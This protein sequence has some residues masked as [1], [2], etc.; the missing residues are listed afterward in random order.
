EQWRALMGGVTTVPEWSYGLWLSRCFYKDE[1]EVRAV[2]ENNRKHNLGA[3]VINLDARAWM[4]AQTRTDFVWDTSRW[5]PYKTFIP[6]LREQGFQVC[7]WENPYVSSATETLYAEGVKNGY[8]AKTAKG[9]VYPYQWVPTGL[10]GFPQPPIA[11]LVDF[12]NA[13]ARTWWKDQH[14]SYL[15]AGVN[16]FKTDFGE[17]IPHDAVFS[18]GST[19]KQL[20]NVYSDLYNLCVMEVVREEC[21]DQGILWARSGY[22]K[23]SKT[24]VKWAGDSQ[25]TW[26]ALRASLRGALSQAVGGAVFWSHDIGGFYG[27][28]PDAELFMRWSQVGLWGSHARMHG[29]SAREPW[30][31][32]S[33][34]LEQV[35]YDVALRKKLHPYFVS[36]GQECVRSQQS[37][38]Q[39]LWLHNTNDPVC[40]TVEDQFYAGSEDVL[41]APFLTP[42]GGRT[43]YLP[44]GHWTC[45]ANGNDY[46][47]RAMHSIDRTSCCPVFVRKNSRWASLFLS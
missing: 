19:G 6:W 15:R 35:K 1:A 26:N 32:G 38:I 36:C 34:A 22:T 29:T 28:M 33:D 41:V 3:T 45:L 42:V 11:G 5:S 20:R 13:K 39:P 47:G 46:P 8:F 37:F 27:P 31:F 17:E 30:E 7:L 9:D 24:P 14:R 2:I 12:T 18:D 4:R 21:G 23:M 16:C 44:E 25:T 40:W 43:V 10:E